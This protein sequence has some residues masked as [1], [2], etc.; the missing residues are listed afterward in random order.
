[1]SPYT[2]GR[3]KQKPNIKERIKKSRPTEAIT[4]LMHFKACF[5]LK[6]GL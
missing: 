4:F 2:A 3:M 5:E 1:M 6:N